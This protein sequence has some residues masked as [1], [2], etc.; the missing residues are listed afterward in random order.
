M[1]PLMGET[2]SWFIYLVTLFIFSHLIETIIEELFPY[3][4]DLICICFPFPVDSC[5]A[6]LG[7][8]NKK[9][10]SKDPANT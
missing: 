8:Y 6:V 9:S 2:G 7:H 4:G 1:L 10:Y 5:L 3:R